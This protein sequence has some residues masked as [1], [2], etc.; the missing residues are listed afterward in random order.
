[1]A[2]SE[3]R[4]GRG[5][6]LPL[7]MSQLAGSRGGSLAIFV[8]KRILWMVPIVFFVILITFVLMHLA[9]GSPWDRTGGRQLS[10]AVMN[11][12]NI[13]YGLDK[14]ETEQFKLYLWNVI[15]FD[16]GLSYQ[17]EGKSVVTLIGG[18]W[19]YTATIGFLA[20]LL[21]VPVGISLGVV[22]A[23]RQN[24]RVAYITMG[25]ETFAASFSN[26]VIGALM[27]VLFSVVLYKSRA[28][29]LF[30][31]SAGYCLFYHLYMTI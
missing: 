4:S 7:R 11:N 19:P 13:K 18:G 2:I 28:C 12:L 26:F 1:M 9:P 10:Q 16:F 3:G 21:I 30:F 15:H 14:P 25:F 31:S 8:G 20:F 24:T 23:L 5:A 6:L 27:V 29:D 17:Y 22:A